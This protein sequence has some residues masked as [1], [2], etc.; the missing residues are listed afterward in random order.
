[1]AL[2]RRPAWEMTASRRFF[3]VRCMLLWIGGSRRLKG[4]GC[5]WMAGEGNVSGGEKNPRADLVK[6]RPRSKERAWRKRRERVTGSLA[7]R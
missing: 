4:E 5:A 3:C 7:L 2:G 1:M 6:R